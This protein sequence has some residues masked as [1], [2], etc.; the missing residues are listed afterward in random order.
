M[1]INLPAVQS[2]VLG[3]QRGMEDLKKNASDL[4]SA[5]QFDSENPVD[6]TKALVGLDEDRLQVE[7]S[8]KA[9]KTIDS[10]V[11]S[12]LDVKA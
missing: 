4:A 11:G 12:I 2:A 1:T 9:L 3:I 7:A 6:Q 5:K 8:A 10:T